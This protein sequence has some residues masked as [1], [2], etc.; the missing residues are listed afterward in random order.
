PGFDRLEQLAKDSTTAAKALEQVAGVQVSND[1]TK[2]RVAYVRYLA[3]LSLGQADACNEL[4]AV[5]SIAAK[6]SKATVIARN[7]TETCTD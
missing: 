6:S 7:L 2:V 3:K 1:E 4:K 5:S